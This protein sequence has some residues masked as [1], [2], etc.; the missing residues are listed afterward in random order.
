M[1]SK[2][3]SNILT[4]ITVFLATSCAH[5]QL[6]GP[7]QDVMGKSHT[8]QHFTVTIPDDP[9]WWPINPD[10]TSESLHLVV[11]DTTK[12][13]AQPIVTK[14]GDTG[15]MLFQTSG[16]M[17]HPDASVLY[18][19][20]IDLYTAELPKDIEHMSDKDIIDGYFQDDMALFVQQGLLSAG[21]PYKRIKLKT[22][23]RVFDVFRVQLDKKVSSELFLACSIIQKEGKR[24]LLVGRLD[25]AKSREKDFDYFEKLLNGIVAK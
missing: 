18:E 5:M 17:S 16:G 11:P 8:Y 12:V 7:R 9:R 25:S 14:E 1:I 15:M 10:K 23:E 6:L 24:Q 3:C 21:S 20:M 19:A 4:I 2:M 13:K 22:H